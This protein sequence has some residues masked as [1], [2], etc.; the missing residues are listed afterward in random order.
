MLFCELHVTRS[1]RA[2]H[3]RLTIKMPNDHKPLLHG[4]TMHESTVP[5][6]TR[7]EETLDS[8]HPAGTAG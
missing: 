2:S 6:M 7:N 1:Q 5:V 8:G 3:S 4:T